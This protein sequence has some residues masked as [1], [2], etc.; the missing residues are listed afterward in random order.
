[1]VCSFP[2]WDWL[3]QWEYRAGDLSEQ[4]DAEVPISLSLPTWGSLGMVS[5]SAHRHPLGWGEWCSEVH[6]PLQRA[7]SV[8]AAC[9]VGHRTVVHRQERDIPFSGSGGPAAVS[10]PVEAAEPV[11]GP[12]AY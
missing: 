10:T 9:F 7:A 2:S 4:S 6:V 5:R 11:A 8:I 12:S 1:M 3:A